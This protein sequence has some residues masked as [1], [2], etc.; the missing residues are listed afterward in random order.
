[1]CIYIYIC[2]IYIH[3]YHGEQMKVSFPCIRTLSLSLSLSFLFPP[4][5]R[6]RTPLSLE[7]HAS[8]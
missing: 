6:E 1:M 8:L 2:P 3:A 4:F 7:T 5:T